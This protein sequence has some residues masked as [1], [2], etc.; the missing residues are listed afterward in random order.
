MR[1][2]APA[3]AALLLTSSLLAPGPAAADVWRELVDADGG[4]A[5][6]AAKGDLP[7]AFLA[8]LAEDAIA[9][10]PGPM[11]AREFW[12]RRAPARERLAW[13]TGHA[14]VA[15]S[16]DLGYTLSPWR[17]VR[18]P[19]VRTGKDGDG[20]KGGK[21]RKRS[22]EDGQA[23][24]SDDPAGLDEHEADEDALASA[25]GHLLNI[26]V[27]RPGSGWRLLA[28]HGIGHGPVALATT[29][30]RRGSLFM[31]EAPVWPVGLPE[32]RLADLEPAGSVRPG[33]V[34]AD[35]I[36][37][38]DGRPPD[39]G[40]QS[41]ALDAGSPRRF[42]AG[43]AISGAGDLAVT[44][45]GATGAVRWLRVWRRPL[46]SDPPGLGWRL[47]VDLSQAAQRSTEP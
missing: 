37:L 16:G 12:A 5:E 25:H 2:L 23:G 34:A 36:R 40:I 15:I 27:R 10:G 17:Y 20:G 21:A 1:W 14:E 33:L 26:W 6:A 46:A 38:R 47:A 19:E 35:F 44:W 24:G 7:A 31:G 4:L 29:A 32:L 22:K 41:E 11:P 43:M 8:V 3:R 45:G 13:R 39:A 28:S 9:F 30:I 42:Q 18:L